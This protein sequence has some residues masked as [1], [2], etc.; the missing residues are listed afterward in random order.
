[1]VAITQFRFLSHLLPNKWIKKE[2]EKK[3]LVAQ[4]SIRWLVLRQINENVD[5]QFSRY[6]RKNYREIE[7]CFPVRISRFSSRAASG[8]SCV[9]HENT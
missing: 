7:I 2:R 8:P 1:M 4:L 6:G 3:K 5:A 9:V